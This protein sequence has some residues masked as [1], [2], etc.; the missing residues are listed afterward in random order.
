MER[1][2]HVFQNTID[3]RLRG[4]HHSKVVIVLREPTSLIFLNM[5]KK[6]LW[7]KKFSNVL[8]IFEDLLTHQLR[9]YSLDPYPS[10]KW[11]NR[12]NCNE[13]GKLY[14][15]V[16][17]DLKK[18]SIQ[19]VFMDDIPKAFKYTKYGKKLLVGNEA[20]YI[21]AFAK[22]MNIQLI[23]I[24]LPNMDLE[25]IFQI[26]SF[27][28][29]E[30]SVHTFT[31]HYLAQSGKS[32]PLDIERWCI[33][34]PF[35]N[36]LP[37]SQLVFK[38]FDMKTWLVIGLNV[39]FVA[40]VLQ[41][42]H[43]T[44]L[45]A[46][47]FGQ[48][49]LQSLSIMMFSSNQIKRIPVPSAFHFLSRFCTTLIFRNTIDTVDDLIKEDLR[50]M[51]I[52]YETTEIRKKAN[53]DEKFFKL[54]YP[55]PYYDVVVQRNN[56]NSNFAYSISQSD[57]IHLDKQQSKLKKPLFRLSTICYGRHLR[58][59]RLQYDSHLKKHLDDFI[60][61][62]K[63]GGLD[64]AW[65]DESFRMAVSMKYSRILVD[66]STVIKPLSLE[67]F[68]KVFIVLLVGIGLS[69]MCFMIEVLF[70]KVVILR[71]LLKKK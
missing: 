58:M 51:I 63:E 43:S 55:M 47:A 61:R 54:L 69:V 7:S 34:V 57:W 17:K 28:D 56:F 19:T 62:V 11:V 49:L 46:D 67:F 16:T 5:L 71:F 22:Y 15:E 4:M 9:M 29:M 21:G 27:H 35:R 13:T 60:L 26:I 65:K 38:T 1:L 39:V 32:Y 42:I 3:I 50:I 40:V 6:W 12:T 52:D 45:T 37:K 70:K 18:Y 48:N 31:M 30:L 20:N 53:F 2:L 14:T 66:K 59:F 8:T 44:P 36:E 10:A 33:M 64:V 41:F 24:F 23:P 25:K 68:E